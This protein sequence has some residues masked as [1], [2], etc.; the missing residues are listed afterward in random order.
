MHIAT[1]AGLAEQP[2]KKTM[3]I[4]LKTR[5]NKQNMHVASNRG[6][7]GEPIQKSMHIATK[8]KISVNKKQTYGN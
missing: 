6:R 2:Y 3:H 8:M 1:N 7:S 4:V 5:E